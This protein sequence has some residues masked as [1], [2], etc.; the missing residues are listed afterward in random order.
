MILVPRRFFEIRN[1]YSLEELKV[2]D[3]RLVYIT[4]Y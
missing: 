2:V 3:V 4:L 1:I